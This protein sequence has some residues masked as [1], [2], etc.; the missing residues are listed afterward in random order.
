MGLWKWGGVKVSGVKWNE[1]VPTFRTRLYYFYNYAAGQDIIYPGAAFANVFFG[2]KYNE[3]L[4]GIRAVA[5]VGLSYT[6]F[7][8][9]CI[10]MVIAFVVG[11]FPPF[12]G[13]F[14][15]ADGDEEVSFLWTDR[16]TS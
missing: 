8:F 13:L 2:I 1:E 5:S 15:L 4:S 14:C 7:L 9:G 3:T 11:L 10:F 6:H 12:V 16:S